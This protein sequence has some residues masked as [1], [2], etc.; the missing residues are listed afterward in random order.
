MSAAAREA[1]GEGH[2]AGLREVDVLVLG[3]GSAGSRAARA[4]R[5]A[6]AST[7][8]VEAG[9]ELGG[10]CILR[11][12][13]PTKTLLE[14]AHRV[15][16]IRDARRFAIEVGAPH[17]DFEA[18]MER[19][20]AL[21][22]R[23]QRAKVASITGGGFE[24]VRGTPRFVS[25]NEVEVDGQR[26]RARAIVIATGSKTREIAGCH[27]A[28]V[29][30]SDD[31]FA[32]SEAPGRVVVLGAGAVGLEL[33]T[34]LARMGTRVTLVNRSPIFGHQDEVF[35][36]EL[37]DA[38]VEEMEVLVPAR[39]VEARRDGSETLVRIEITSVEHAG[40][41]SSSAASKTI[42]RPCDFVLNATGRVPSFDGLDVEAAGLAVEDGRI[43]VDA[44]LRAGGEASTT[45]LAGDASDL[46][47]ILHEANREGE[48]AG[49]NAARLAGRLDGTLETL[50]PRVPAMSVVF[51]DP[52]YASVG[53][54]PQDCERR[55]LRY[56]MAQKRFPEQGRGIV[57]GARFGGLR[58][59]AA[60]DSDNGGRRLL[61]AQILGARA[62]DLI[63]IPA[64]I[65]TMGGSVDDLHRVPWYHPT[66]A[67]A[68][69]EVTRALR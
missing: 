15:A 6:G 68:F 52:V 49:R 57:Q 58:I 53:L 48:V 32:L 54:T 28:R 60:L 3:V 9:D 37:R 36:R 38:L 24:L 5:E 12:C 29:L 55:G 51:S 33:A 1:P 10:L 31:V 69:I 25:R 63:H 21:V 47:G 43:A 61:G 42:E 11:G 56:R 44:F 19:T 50:D 30:T 20:R 35:G 7:V 67:E 8:A 46:H 59:V 2:A 14:T 17:V 65:L 23:F 64:A 22:A 45:L 41:A 34:F 16:E 62:D 27:D 26:Y 4:A 39:F 13:M 18:L 66:L 40:A